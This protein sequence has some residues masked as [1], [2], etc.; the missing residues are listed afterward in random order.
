M[1]VLREYKYSRVYWY[2]YVG[3]HDMLKLIFNVKEA[4]DLVNTENETSFNKLYS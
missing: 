4:K 2:H 1:L 3:R